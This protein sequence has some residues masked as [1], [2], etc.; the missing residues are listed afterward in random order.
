MWFGNS[1]IKLRTNKSHVMFSDYK[2][3][4]VWADRCHDIIL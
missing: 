2:H 3:E 4:Q 1:Y